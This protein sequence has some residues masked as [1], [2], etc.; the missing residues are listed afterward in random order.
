[1]V[2]RK[3][4][5]MCD[6]DFKDG[7]GSGLGDQA[8]KPAKICSKVGFT[9]LLEGN[10]PAAAQARGA[11]RDDINGIKDNCFQPMKPECA[12]QLIDIMKLNDV[13]KQA[14]SSDFATNLTSSFQL[15]YL[16]FSKLT[17]YCP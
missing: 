2:T 8:N 13:D 15:F 1:M 3:D 6:V 11:T 12:Q 16:L 7:K 10:I 4:N 17:A 14:T 9:N 5:N